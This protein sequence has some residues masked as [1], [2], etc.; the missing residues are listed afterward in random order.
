MKRLYFGFLICLSAF[1]IFLP[2]GIDNGL[3][4][5]AAAG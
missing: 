1:F 3:K 2:A 4:P 5:W